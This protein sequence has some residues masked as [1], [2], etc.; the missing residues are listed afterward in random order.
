MN[1]RRR[2]FWLLV[3]SL[4]S[5]AGLIFSILVYSPSTQ[6]SIYNFQFTILPVFFLLIFTFLFSL[7]FYLLRS[8]RRAALIGLLTIIYLIFRMLNLNSPYFLLLLIA[9][10]ISL[11]LFFKKHI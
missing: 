10:F 1:R 6:F 4:L 8:T 11:E 3:I 5:L 9:L 7:I 2:P